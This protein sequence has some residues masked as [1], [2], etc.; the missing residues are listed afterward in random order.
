MSLT[1]LVAGTAVVAATV[2]LA[3]LGLTAFAAAKLGYGPVILLNY[4][5]LREAVND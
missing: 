4:N 2:V 1:T 5:A 3:P